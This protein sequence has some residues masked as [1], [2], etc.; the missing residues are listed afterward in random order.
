MSN[1]VKLVIIY[2]GVLGTNLLIRYFKTRFLADESLEQELIIGIFRK[3]I[4][5]VI[6]IVLIRYLKNLS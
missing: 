3:A 2:L 4:L 5:I 6:T 1:K